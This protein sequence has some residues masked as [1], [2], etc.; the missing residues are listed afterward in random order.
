M[1][2]DNGGKG[3][4]CVCMCHRCLLKDVMIKNNYAYDVKYI[5]AYTN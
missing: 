2:F 4:M 3:S 5:T 1:I